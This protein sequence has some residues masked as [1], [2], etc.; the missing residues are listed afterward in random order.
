MR[1][2]R[3]DNQFNYQTYG[4]NYDY[5]NEDYYIEQKGGYYY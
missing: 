1:E 4:N 5:E 2:K 3:Y